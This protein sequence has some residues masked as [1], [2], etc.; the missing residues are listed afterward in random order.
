VDTAKKIILLSR[1][2]LL[3]VILMAFLI[4]LFFTHK[5]NTITSDYNN[6]LM[7]VI[8]NQG[9]DIRDVILLNSS[10]IKSG[11][12]SFKTMIEKS[13]RYNDLW[14]AFII[15]SVVVSPANKLEKKYINKLDEDSDVYLDL[16]EIKKIW[17]PIFDNIKSA[18]K[19]RITKDLLEEK[20]FLIRVTDSINDRVLSDIYNDSFIGDISI[21][22][23]LII[24]SILIGSIFVSLF[25]SNRKIDSFSSRLAMTIEEE[26]YTLNISENS[27]FPNIAKSVNALFSVITK[28]KQK[29]KIMSNQGNI[30]KD[31]IF[32]EIDNIDDVLEDISSE[33]LNLSL[34]PVDDEKDLVMTTNTSDMELHSHIDKKTT[35]ILMSNLDKGIKILQKDLVNSVDELKEVNEINHKND[36]VVNSVN[37]KMSSV[38]GVLNEVSSN[39]SHSLQSFN[40]LGETVSSISKT[41]NFIK[42]I[43]EQTKLLALNAAI[44]AARAGEVGRGF[45]VVADEIRTLSEN[46]NEATDQIEANVN[47]LVEE[48]ENINSQFEKTD[49]KAQNSLVLLDSFKADFDTVKHNSKIV[50]FRNSYLAE[51]SFMNLVQLDH[52]LF[53][54]GVYSTL[55]DRKKDVKV[56]TYDLCRFGKWYY[57]NLQNNSLVSTFPSYKYLEEP[58]KEVHNRSQAI[59]DIVNNGDLVANEIE[60]FEH[61]EKVEMSSFSLFSIIADILREF[62]VSEKEN[63]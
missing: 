32:N 40:K 34:K 38:H 20:E 37:K 19:H 36:D 26:A 28:E 7:K 12:E 2:K 53:K 49:V 4:I 43:S 9:N 61:L 30:E 16:V 56:S 63:T 23:I 5:H 11:S 24:L 21:K 27:I 18:S 31:D 60:L 50:K 25:L 54:V 35:S 57:S 42:E 55:L 14:N 47:I 45:A 29:Y 39:I 58:H 41:L 33:E 62:H 1:E 59:C 10:T 17:D 15:G 51:S 44:E 22:V 48:T 52:I 3:S 6:F 13:N 46:T 8:S